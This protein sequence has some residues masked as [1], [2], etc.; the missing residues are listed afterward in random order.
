MP[1]WLTAAH[2]KSG[3]KC[4][5]EVT[6]QP[7]TVGRSVTGELSPR[8]MSIDF[9]AMLS[10]R[11]FEAVLEGDQMRIRGLENKH[12]MYLRGEPVSDFTV[13]VGQHF[14]SGQTSFEFAQFESSLGEPTRSNTVMLDLSRLREMDS[15]RCLKALL[16]LQP[17]LS[18]SHD[19][20]SLLA[21]ALPILAQIVPMAASILAI[22]VEGEEFVTVA[23][24]GADARLVPSRT[25]LRQA[26]LTQESL[27]YFWD[28]S[29]GSLAATMVADVRWAVASPIRSGGDQSFVLYAVGSESPFAP[30][31]SGRTPGDLDRAVLTFVAGVLGQHL[32]GRWAAQQFEEERRQRYLAQ[33]LREVVADLTATL[34]PTH[35]LHCLQEHLGKLV[36]FNSYRVFQQ[37]IPTALADLHDPLQLRAGD[38]RLGTL[39]LPQPSHVLCLPL[40]LRGQ[41]LG[42]VWLI[43]QQAYGPDEQ[44]LAASLGAQAAVALDNASMFKTV[45]RLASVDE[46]TQVANRRHFFRQAEGLREQALKNG[47]PVTVMLLDI[48][49]FKSFNDQHGHQVGDEVL[50]R[51]ACRAQPFFPLFGRYGGE[52][53]AGACGE[54]L[55]AAQRRAEALRL[56]IEG[57]RLDS[58]GGGNVTVSIGLACCPAGHTPLQTLLGRAD[59]ALYAAKRAGRNQV[60][61]EPVTA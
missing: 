30:S 55:E 49:H 38:A 14:T 28:Q 24:H 22:S 20:H 53:F 47:G 27:C 18:C 45:E 35:I 6:H 9:D 33:T 56:A 61:V 19:A 17:L 59:E 4:R 39:S 43:R 21:S 40:S 26:A 5:L 15:E 48:D 1:Y 10:R 50:Q 34:D 60:C 52:E 42:Q 41:T 13:A 46:L 3:A 23:S 32:R 44:S 51:V 12:P 8:K 36:G 54:P 2:L 57:E 11:H 58:I 7:L 31:S 16:D 37:G 25:L 29:E